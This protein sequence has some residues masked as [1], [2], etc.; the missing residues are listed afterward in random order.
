VKHFFFVEE[1][2]D[3][4]RDDQEEARECPPGAK[5]QRR[6]EQHENGAKVHG[7]AHEAIRPGRN[8]ALAFFDLD[9]ARGKTVFFHDPKGDEIASEDEELGKNRQPNWDAGPAETVIQSG[10]H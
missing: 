9:G 7:M 10:N 6:E 8:D 1:A 2:E 3:D 5:R 4:Q